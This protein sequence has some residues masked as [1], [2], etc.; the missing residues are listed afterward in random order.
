MEN[1]ENYNVVISGVTFRHVSDGDTDSIYKNSEGAK[2]YVLH[3]F[4]VL[5]SD[6][7]RENDY[8][9]FNG[10]DNE[11]G[12]KALNTYLMKKG[13]D[14]EDGH[15]YNVSEEVYPMSSTCYDKALYG[16]CRIVTIYE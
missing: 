7:F 5:S 14:I 3:R 1:P 12:D 11:Q 2:L 10:F 15:T 16:D 9:L 4:C 8:L 6:C 13:I